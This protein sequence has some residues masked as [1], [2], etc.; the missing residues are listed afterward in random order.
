M[1]VVTDFMP[2]D[3]HSV[4][5]HAKPHNRARVVRLVECLAGEMTMHHV[6]DPAPGFARLPV[7][8]SI[9]DGQL[10]ADAQKLHLCLS[11]TVELDGPD[12]TFH[13]RAT[14]AVAFALHTG[15]AGKLPGAGRGAS[16][17]RARCSARVSGTGGTGL[18]RSTTTVP[19]RCTSGDR[20]WRSSS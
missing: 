18:V 7:T 2:V 13:L 16:S 15:V 19:I 17:E 8:L 4:V 14:D 12:D 20:R 1:V 11:S 9:E 5:Q 10:H 6:F 3:E